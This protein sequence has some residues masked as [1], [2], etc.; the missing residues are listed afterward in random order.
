[1]TITENDHEGFDIP[2]QASSP[3]AIPQRVAVTPKP[4]PVAEVKPI[5]QPE[6]EPMVPLTFKDALEAVQKAQSD[7]EAAPHRTREQQRE[8]QK[9]WLQ[10]ECA[11]KVAFDLQQGTP[12]PSQHYVNASCVPRVTSEQ[13][14]A[15]R[16]E[17]QRRIILK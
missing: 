8:R 7:Y 17:V 12:P 16:P 4:A 11:K 5:P 2:A 1:M 9:L 14:E 6:A 3:P 15:I 13:V 10:M